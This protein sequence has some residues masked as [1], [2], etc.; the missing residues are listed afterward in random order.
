MLVSCPAHVIA[1]YLGPILHTAEWLMNAQQ[2]NGNWPTKASQDP[3]G[4]S[5]SQDSDGELVQWCH[6]AP[7][8]VILFST[9]LQRAR[10]FNL[11]TSLS[12][13]FKDSLRRG[14]E[15]TYQRGFLRKGVGL[16]HGVG[17]S[18]YALLRAA[19][20]LGE[21]LSEHSSSTSAGETSFFGKAVH[22]AWMA[23]KYDQMVENGE[24]TL[25]DAPYSLYEGLAGMC[26]AW[27]E[28][29]QRLEIGGTGGGMPGFDD[30]EFEKAL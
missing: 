22:L 5:H 20:A 4:R 15:L 8:P 27:A 1:P 7:G 2:P 3:T 26:C 19:D 23:T 16:C 14:A 25:A 30:L 12:N 6:G 11:S 29:V 13:A 21:T 9:I 10:D 17:S 24:M 28:I 18:V